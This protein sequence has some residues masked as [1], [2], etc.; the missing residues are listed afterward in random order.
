MKL[1]LI[2]VLF[3]TVTFAEPNIIINNNGCCQSACKKPKVITKTKVV[4]KEV[5]KIVERVVPRVEYKK[6][7]VFEEAPHHILGLML[8]QGY[9]GLDTTRISL[10]TMKIDEARDTGIGAFYLYRFDSNV[11]V[12]GD[13]DSLRHYSL[14]IGVGF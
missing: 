1:F 12:G 7:K 4:E 6:V 11:Y 3:T 8:T 9:Y 14:K 5:I 2:T 10:D 13:I